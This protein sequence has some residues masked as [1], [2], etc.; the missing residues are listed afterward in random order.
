[1]VEKKKR[2]KIFG[3]VQGV[4]FR[5]FVVSRGRELGLRGWAKNLADGSVEVAAAGDASLLSKL[6]KALGQGPPL[7]RVTRVE[8]LEPPALLDKKTGFTVEY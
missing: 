2:W 7:A 3:R 1:M 4:Y 5:A 8:T 6:E